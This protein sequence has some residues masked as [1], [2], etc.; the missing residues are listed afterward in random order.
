LDTRWLQDFL[1][2]A[3]TGNFTRAAELRHTSQ[4][5]FS[6]RIQQLEAWVGA[7]LIDRSTFPARLLPEGE[8]FRDRAGE[9]LRQV[10][11]ARVDAAG[12]GPRRPDHVRIA[13]P[14]ALAT[15][16]L[17]DWWERWSADGGLTAGVTLGNVHDIVSAF[18]AGAA[19]LLVCF[20]HAQAPLHLD[21]KR[22][23]RAVI[24]TERVRPYAAP[25]LLAAGPLLPGSEAI[26]LPLLAYSPG[27]YFA[28]I[29]D[30]VVEGAPEPLHAARV[31]ESDMSDVLRGLAVAGVGVAWLPEST[32]RAVSD[33]LSPLP[34]PGWDAEL[35]VVAF[36][37]RWDSP[38]A[39][40]RLWSRLV[41]DSTATA[42]RPRNP[43][44]PSVRIRRSA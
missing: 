41:K 21:P 25:A 17:P 26:P 27:V 13:V 12:E 20:H 33:A 31:V 6:R 5:A 8:R 42:P 22:Y 43:A 37:D 15:A 2:V 18:L 1:A 35:S 14:N 40:H 29:F 11:D 38:R 19:D 10:V 24:G 16:R 23:E 3:E 39:V 34:T 44:G 36:R 30:F 28:R 9:I 32:A 7:P 4:A